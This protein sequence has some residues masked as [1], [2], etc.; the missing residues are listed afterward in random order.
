M[1]G[2]RQQ[3]SGT[4][5]LQRNKRGEKLGHPIV[6]STSLQLD[7]GSSGLNRQ[8]PAST[9]T[10]QMGS[11][12]SHT[13][14]SASAA[15]ASSEASP[16]GAS[17]SPAS[18]EALS[19][20]AES[21]P[22]EPATPPVPASVDPSASVPPLPPTGERHGFGLLSPL[23]AAAPTAASAAAMNRARRARITSRDIVWRVRLAPI[24]LQGA[25]FNRSLRRKRPGLR[26]AAHRWFA[27][28]HP[29]TAA[30]T[31]AT[32]SGRL[33]MTSSASSRSTR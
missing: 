28:A 15:S 9:S 21:D 31:C 5:A 19:D 2:L 13:P 24:L 33:R 25:G 6:S 16:T 26:P 18:G 29:A 11:G 30:L 27:R 22:P 7:A 12:S 4:S 14:A 8:N 20:R 3:R 1:P 32:A 23:Q 10:P 17:S